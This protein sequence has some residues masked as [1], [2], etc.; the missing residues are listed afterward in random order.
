MV[1]ECIVKN[2]GLGVSQIA[3]ELSLNKSTVFSIL[4]TLEGMGYIYVSEP[5]K[6]YCATFKIR[7]LASQINEKNSIVEYARPFLEK[8][9]KK[10]NETIHFV[11]SLKDTVEYI[12]KIESAK[13]IRIH[14]NIGSEMPM[15]CTSVGKAILAW[16]TPE[17]I[18]EYIQYNGLTAMTKKSIVDEQNLYKELELIRE[19]GYSI[20]DEENMEGLYCIG[21]PIRNRIGVVSYSV[22]LALPKYRLHE[23]NFDIVLSDLIRTAEEISGFF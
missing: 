10:Y 15:H 14:T 20:D 23:I 2:G 3:K 18:A 22:S 13:S 8:N 17:K 5:S 1:F 6:N 12:D 21:V 4:K 19:R 11:Y 9:L 16:R 7:T